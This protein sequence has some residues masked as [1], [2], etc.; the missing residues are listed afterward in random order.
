[1]VG[2]LE[3]SPI[4]V[5]R[6]VAI[7]GPCLLPSIVGGW[8]CP[9]KPPIWVGKVTRLYRARLRELVLTR[10]LPSCHCPPATGAHHPLNF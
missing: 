6:R 5:P 8:A 3:K 1:M 2:N 7:V 4:P 9:P 10:A